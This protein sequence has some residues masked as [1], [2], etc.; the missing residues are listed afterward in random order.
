MQLTTTEHIIRVM[1]I[2]PEGR[3][4]ILSAAAARE[5]FNAFLEDGLVNFII[6]LSNVLFL[7]SA[8][9]AVLINLLKQS[10]QLGGNVTLVWPQEPAVR[11]TLSLTRFDHVFDMVDSVE[12]AMK[13][14][15]AAPQETHIFPVGQ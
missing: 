11:R 8:G 7:D 4:D 5:T 2:N 9:M 14:F 15:V 10:R 3:F 1:I 6:D 12:A 13:G